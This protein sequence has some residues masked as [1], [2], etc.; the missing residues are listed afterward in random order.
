MLPGL[1]S[2]CSTPAREH[3]AKE[4]ERLV[5]RQRP[6][7]VEGLFE[8]PPLHELH[9]EPGLAVVLD[10]VADGDDVRVN[11]P[12]L[13]AALAQQAAAHAASRQG[14]QLER[15]H[16]AEGAVPDAVHPREP[17]LAQD[18]L[19]LI[20]IDDLAGLKHRQRAFGW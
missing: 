4:A 8:A 20:P 5:E 18:R 7:G 6:A 2:R 17:A 3:L 12:C 14:E 15:V 19:D 9:E 1:R 10:H 11:E 16:A 13:D